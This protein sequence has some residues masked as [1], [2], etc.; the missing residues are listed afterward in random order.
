MFFADKRGGHNRKSIQE[1]FFRQWSPPMAYILGLLFADGA[2]LDARK[3]SRTCY[4]QLTSKDKSLLEIV[5]KLMDSSH[6][7]TRRKPEYVFFKE[8]R[9]FRSEIYSLRIGSKLMY[10]DLLKKGLTPNKSLVMRFPFVPRKYLPFF[11]RGYFDGDGCVSLHT[12]KNGKTPEAQ[13]VFT[14]GSAIFLKKLMEE[15]TSAIGVSL[16]QICKYKNQGAYRLRYRK[17]EGLEILKFMYKSLDMA[18]YLKRKFDIYLNLINY[19]K[20][21]VI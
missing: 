9:Y 19:R 12:R 7:I 5:R 6:S 21:L 10:Q 17:A 13:V 15:F 4:I 18:P 16:K 11:I 2:L 8:K 14:S 3:S 20:K 1:L